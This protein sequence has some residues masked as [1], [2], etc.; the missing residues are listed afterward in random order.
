VIAA[1]T[2]EE[3][4]ILALFH[5]I[6][7]TEDAMREVL[8]KGLLWDF[9]DEASEE[10]A[11][12]RVMNDPWY[13]IGTVD[14]GL[15][16]TVERAYSRFIS[17]ARMRCPNGDLAGAMAGGWVSAP[18]VKIYHFVLNQGP[19]PGEP[20][21]G[22]LALLWPG[23]SPVWALHTWDMFLLAGLPG[24]IFGFPLHSWTEQDVAMSVRLQKAIT[25]F[26]AAGRVAAWDTGP[27]WSP[28]G[29]DCVGDRCGATMVFSPEGNADSA[30]D[31]RGVLGQSA[32]AWHR[33]N[34]GLWNT[35]LIN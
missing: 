21:L 26:G 22:P 8:R 13:K 31:A 32:C 15:P 9:A 27:A 19:G 14:G 33:G 10:A 7:D 23:Y 5:A 24:S 25:E 30:V 4:D 34:F 3:L 16:T 1:T 35:S 18:D 6:P 2:A 28:S 17:D 29:Y 11:L 20:L 12:D